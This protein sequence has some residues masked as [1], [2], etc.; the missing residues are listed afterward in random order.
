[1]DARENVEAV[2]AMRSALLSRMLQHPHIIF[3][4]EVTAKLSIFSRGFDI[5]GHKGWY[6]RFAGGLPDP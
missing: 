3:M 2:L 6:F 4:G 5:K 1:M